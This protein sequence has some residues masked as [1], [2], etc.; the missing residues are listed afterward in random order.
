M[1][2]FDITDRESFESLEKWY[3]ELSKYGEESAE[4]IVIGNKADLGAQRQVSSQEAIEFAKKL[5][6]QYIETSV[7]TG[8]NIKKPFEFLVKEIMENLKRS[9]GQT[10]SESMT[11]KYS[12]PMRTFTN[13]E[14]NR[15]SISLR[16]P[17]AFVQEGID[18]DKKICK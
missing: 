13:P 5:S 2:V 16:N 15:N 7:Y 9:E 8:T 3:E 4:I 1:M 6:S 17:P 14:I 11:R 12:I 10:I 18:N